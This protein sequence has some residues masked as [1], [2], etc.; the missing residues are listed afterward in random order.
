MNWA[1]SAPGDDRAALTLFRRSWVLATAI[2]AVLIT[3]F[4]AA[5]L[6]QSR[7]YFT[8]GFLSIDY[9]QGPVDVVVFLVTSLFVDAA[10]V[11]LVTAVAAWALSR[12]RLRPQAAVLAGAL[13]GTS[14]LLAA[15]V[16][17]YQI[18]RYL[19]DAFDLALMF[20]LTGRSISE[21]FAV[22]STHRA[23]VA[24]V[25]LV[26]GGAAAGGIWAANRH[27]KHHARVRF[28][29]RV[30]MIPAV[31]AL[32][33]TAVL[34]AAANA[35]DT[36]EN[37]LLR[38]PAGRAMAMV[39]NA[40]TDVD[41]DRFGAVG[42]SVDPDPFDG[43][44]FPYAVDLP[45]N[46]VDED[47]IAGDLP[48]EAAVFEE[49]PLQ[50]REWRRRPDVV[51]IVLESFRADVVGARLNGKPV[52]P[53]IDAVVG[54]GASV[55][56]AF[57]HNGYTIQSRHH[58]FTGSLLAVPSKTTLIDDFLANGYRVGYFSAQDESFGGAAYDVGFAR[59][60]VASD[61]RADRA[62]RYST[63]TTA[64]SLVV[65]STVVQERIGQFLDTYGP[66]EAPLFL[67]VNFQET[68][69][70]YSHPGIE[71][72][73]SP[74]RLDRSRIGPDQRAALWETYLNTAATVDRAV[75]EV[76]EAVRRA[77][78]AEPGVVITAD[79]GESLFDE[80]FLGHG[81]A[82]N[83]VQTR[84]PLVVANLPMDLQQPFG[85]AELRAALGSALQKGPEVSS[86]PTVSP[87]ANR[88]VFQYL[89][90][91]SRPRQI[92]FLQNGERTVYDFRSRRL[93]V[94]NGPWS[95]ADDLTGSHREIFHRLVHWW[96]AIGLARRD[97]LRGGR[98][99]EK[100]P[101][102][103]TLDP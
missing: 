13:A 15:D 59:A 70:P 90:D 12:S 27:W 61:A 93:R 76:L 86:M 24:H 41:R 6:Q 29:A 100:S 20:D 82:L 79:H 84:V 7:S 28:P 91:L 37:G 11:G 73:I 60:T 51:L 33:G 92:A 95:T 67:Y 97:N 52:T 38:K 71:T 89:G 77:R 23:A 54:R 8:G 68:H 99:N 64:G 85:Q 9:L 49:T 34:T 69:F 36:L 81:Y 1:L 62:R 96:E 102:P 5:L 53:V 25:A 43:S 3:L 18:L 45:G 98:S 103:T 87:A 40:V 44:V 65:P 19:G 4:D 88:V 35:S 75:G 58:L 42:R 16:A 57:S 72:L 48:R 21:M 39:V 50:T 14:L 46:G 63:S 83:D 74:A 26:A 2:G 17:S 30:L 94:A 66:G 78:R 47:G 10:F 56:A 32:F 101:L 22:A 80:G 31:V 55:D